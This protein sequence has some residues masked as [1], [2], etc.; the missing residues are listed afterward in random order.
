MRR[1]LAGAILVALTAGAVGAAALPAAADEPLLGTGDVWRFSDDGTDPSGDGSLSWTTADFDDAGWA[2]GVG[3]FG[4]KRGEADLGGGFVAETLLAY[5]LPGSENTVPTYH[6]RTDLDLTAEQ[7]AEFDALE[8]TVVYDD[9][10]RIY[11]NGEQ[12]AGFEDERVDEA[13]NPNL[14]YAGSSKGNPQTSTFTV[15]AEALVEGE[16]T[17]A[18]A[19]YQDRETSSDI[20]FDL[21]SLVPFDY[22]TEPTISDIVL[23]VGA[24][25]ADR[26]VAWYSD[27]DVPQ[28]AQI[29]PADEVDG[30]T[31]PAS[32]V[33]AETTATGATTSGEFF[34]DAT[35]SG[36]EENTEY[37]YRV[38][39]ESTGWSD[40][41]T[42]RTQDFSGDFSFLFFG[43]P[44]VGAS[45]D[46]AHDEAGWVDTV[47]VATETYP[48]AELLFSAGDQVEHANNEDQYDAFL[49]PEQLRSVPLVATNGNHDVGSKAYEQHFNL[50]NEDLSAGAGTATSSGGDYWFLYKD[51]LFLNINSNSR[52]Y[53]SHNAFMEKVVAEHGDEAKW[54]VLAFHHSIYSVASHTDDG[55]ILDR[56]ST[57]PEKI[58]ELGIDVVLMG[59]D[60]NYTRSYLVQDGELADPT[61]L[62]GQE[63]VEK[64]DGEVLY[65]TANSASGSK[66]YDTKA[67]DAWFASV[68]NQ[69]RVRNYSAVEVTDDAFTLRT[70][71]SEAN[72]DEDPVNSVVDE[73]VLSRSAAPELTTP[74]DV[75]VEQDAAFD[76]LEGVT[77]I[78]DVDGDLTDAIEV[79]GEVDTTALGA[80]TLTYTVADARGNV[81]TADRTVTVVEPAAEP[82]DDAESAGEAGAED[83]EADADAVE[84]G[85][86]DAG[87]QG[88]EAGAEDADAD[89]VESGSDDAGEAG[90]ENAD[91][92][93]AG[94]DADDQGA[95][96]AAAEAGSED[97]GVDAGESGSEDATDADAGDAGSEGGADSAD[98]TGT[99]AGRDGSLQAT[100]G[101]VVLPIA[102]I[103]ALLLAG[104]ATLLI[105]RRRALR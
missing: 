82:G 98:Q 58:S 18:V 77:A 43:D 54:T 4:S 99:D 21:A 12:V 16:N 68:I 81:A 39:S 75:E 52:D 74:G 17:I 83:A 50:P 22:P 42:F 87:D 37:A 61:E 24:T 51:V 36:L 93:E 59:H 48:D 72:G 44:Q 6:L 102:G 91:D 14:T 5:T 101:D 80:Y 73:V 94:A 20:F 64:K 66:Y 104:G 57:M 95:E 7:L 55:D 105:L 53:D 100:G 40:V 60:H 47:D 49:A 26:N 31:F 13:E 65:L 2:E 3:P 79:A 1:G 45:G 71:R 88:A 25:E 41:H 30:E 62:A 103:V 76:P 84:S 69:E 10:V 38:G 11:V 78:D 90:A 29:A 33:T 15:P 32:A 8:G 85:T 23:G 35:F 19:L 56:R 9:A 70:L 92:A 27:M 67:P 89:A 34:R 86:E 46:L 63:R 28:V 96:D 97:A